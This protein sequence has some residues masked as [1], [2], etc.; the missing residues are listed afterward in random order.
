[1]FLNHNHATLKDGIGGEIKKQVIEV[2]LIGL[3][4][5]QLPLG[6]TLLG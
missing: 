2:F 5:M 4:V 1:M 6:L 3:V